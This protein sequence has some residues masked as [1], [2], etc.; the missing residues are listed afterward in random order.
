MNAIFTPQI[1]TTNYYNTYAWA[2]SP[3][4][5]IEAKSAVQIAILSAKQFHNRR[6]STSGSLAT[7]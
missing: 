4:V 7:N 5:S 2:V 1:S 6:V 3:I